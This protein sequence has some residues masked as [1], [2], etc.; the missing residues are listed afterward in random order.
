M[1]DYRVYQALDANEYGKHAFGSG[2]LIVLRYL[3]CVK[4]PRFFQPL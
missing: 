3:L 2:N 1:D 4:K